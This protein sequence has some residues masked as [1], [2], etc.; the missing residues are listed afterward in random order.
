MTTPS[1]DTSPTRSRAEPRDI[2]VLVALAGASGAGVVAHAFGWMSLRYSSLF[3]VVPSLIVLVSIVFLR[4]GH[5]DRVRIL[6][7]R[8]LYGAMW[9]LIATLVYDVVRPL[10]VAVAGFHFNPYKAMPIFGSLITGRPRDDALAIAVGWMYHFWNGIGF[11]VM[12]ALVRPHGGWLAGLIWGIG[13]QLFMMAVYPEFL[14]ARLDDLG[15]MV[16]G[17]LG[18]ALWGVTLGW[19]L[20]WRGP[21]V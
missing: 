17:M 14:D 2:V 4:R 11:G 1:T 20:S 5:A 7:D 12:F 19:G 15:F 8:V 3:V 6:G 18:H 13:L 21:K 16:T 10:I 9:G